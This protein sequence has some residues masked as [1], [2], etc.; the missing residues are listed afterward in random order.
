[1]L[2]GSVGRQRDA[3]TVTAAGAHTTISLGGGLSLLL[4][5]SWRSGSSEAGVTGFALL[6]WSAG[7]RTT[8]LGSAQAGPHGVTADVSAQRSVSVGPGY[9]Y[10]IDAKTGGGSPS[11]GL[12]EVSWQTEHGRYD[13]RV[14]GGTGPTA[15]ASA[16]AAG[17]IVLIG[18]RAFATRPV[19]GA[20][21]LVRVG[22]P[23][24]R[25]YAENQEVGSTDGS[26]DVL[27][28]SLMPHYA[29][30]LSIA[31][32]DVPLD[33]EIGRLELLVAPPRKGGAVTRFEVAPIRAV[34]G[35]LLVDDRA[36]SAT[37]EYADLTLQT[38]G[39]KVGAPTTGDGRFFLERVP[40]GQYEAELLG[41]KGSARCSIVIPDATGLRDL[42]DVACTS[43]EAAPR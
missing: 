7:P 17:G 6:S 34:V 28:P 31:A 4:S 15:V 19:Q 35:R 22:V 1:M 39:G 37:A 13:G 25:A 12:A 26:G 11:T 29:N 5:G 38:P 21:A 42:G 2:D 32:S 10:R 14:D 27:V 40:P 30:R 23:G 36:R 9:G 43:S 24:V 8:A 3:G 41:A 16:T 20:F 33:Y 18:G